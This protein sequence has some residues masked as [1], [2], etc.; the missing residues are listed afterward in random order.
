MILLRELKP[1]L[2]GNL[3]RILNDVRTLWEMCPHLVAAL[4]VKTLVV[5]HAIAVTQVLTETDTE[6]HVVGVMVLATQKVRIIRGDDR[7]AELLGEPEDP[8]VQLALIARIVR[9]HLEV[10]AVLEHVRVP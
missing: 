8:R 6:Q 9:L 3:E 10:I 5:P 7:K 4:E 2:V 1:H